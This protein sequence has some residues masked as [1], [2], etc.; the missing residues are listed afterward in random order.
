MLLETGND[1]WVKVGESLPYDDLNSRERGFG[2][3]LGKLDTH[4]LSL[5]G[6]GS[7]GG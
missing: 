5:V 2:G 7:K 6:T 4:L 3:P 1:L